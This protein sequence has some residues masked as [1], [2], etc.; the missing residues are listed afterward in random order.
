MFFSKF[1]KIQYNGQL[2][3]NITQSILLKFK[4]MFNTTLWQFHTIA[5]GETPESIAHKYYQ[6]ASDFWIILLVN[7]I[8]NPY[9]DWALTLNEL[10]SLTMKKYGDTNVNNIHHLI[11]INTKKQISQSEQVKYVKGGGVKNEL[12]FNYIIVTNLEYETIENDKKRDIRILAPK[13]LQE[14][15]NQFEDI[16][17]DNI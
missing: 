11:D 2:S 13:Y 7:S 8:I 9:L 16:L 17:N 14:F 12:P 4:T 10:K 1:Q 5:D 3:T 15:K 6:N